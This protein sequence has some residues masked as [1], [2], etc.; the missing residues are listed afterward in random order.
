[1]QKLFAFLT[2][3]LLLSVTFFAQHTGMS[4]GNL[5]A[6]LIAM[7]AYVTFAMVKS[8]RQENSDE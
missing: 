1:M 5:Y 3:A 2:L 8:N 6:L 7:A 4:A